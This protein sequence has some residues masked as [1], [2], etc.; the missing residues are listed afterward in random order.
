MDNVFIPKSVLNDARRNAFDGL[1]NK[2]IDS[3]ESNNHESFITDGLDLSG[4]N[5]KYNKNIIIFDDETSGL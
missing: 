3:F 1:K 4:A 2:I 5:F